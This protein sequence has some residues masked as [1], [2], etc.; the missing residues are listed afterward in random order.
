MSKRVFDASFKRMAINLSY[1]RGPVKEVAEELGIAPGRIS[2]WRQQCST[3]EKAF[4]GLTDEQKEI[5]R[6]QKE[7]KEI[8]LGRYILKK[9]VASFPRETGD[10]RN[11]KRAPE[12]ISC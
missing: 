8:Q 6:L 1:A 12:P 2:K 7:L 5:R 4:T 3:V 11:Y 10:I 9:T